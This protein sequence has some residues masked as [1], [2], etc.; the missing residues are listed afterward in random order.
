MGHEGTGLEEAWRMGAGLFVLV[1]STFEK[2][3]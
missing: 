3:P 2:A 1:A